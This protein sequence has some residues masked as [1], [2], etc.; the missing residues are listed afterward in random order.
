[1]TPQLQV[2]CHQNQTRIA[3]PALQG[4]VEPEFLDEKR[5]KLPFQRQTQDNWCWA[6]VSSSVSDYYDPSTPYTQ[7]S[8]AS[9]VF[10]ANCCANA[11]A[12][13]CDQPYQLD[14][15]LQITGNLNQS[16]TRNFVSDEI[17]SEIDDGHLIAAGIEWKN[18]NVGHALT[19]FGYSYDPDSNSYYVYISDPAYGKQYIK[20]MTLC[21]NYHAAGQWTDSYTTNAKP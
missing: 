14:K 6:A 2:L 15:A 21:E 4:S 17:K 3:V 8:L 16:Y 1:M 7:C 12:P 20:L 10:K 11:P 5:L 13:Q 19:I 9:T 18:E